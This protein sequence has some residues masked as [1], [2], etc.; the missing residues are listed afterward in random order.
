MAGLQ[1]WLHCEHA[2]SSAVPTPF[3]HSLSTKALAGHACRARVT[4]PVLLAPYVQLA[5]CLVSENVRPL[6]AF[7]MY[8]PLAHGAHD[9][10]SAV[11]LVG[12]LTRRQRLD[13]N[14]PSSQLAVQGAHASLGR[15]S[16]CVLPEQTTSARM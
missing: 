4:E 7:E 9:T 11:S 6:H 10:H 1:F 13:T 12:L 15:V 2:V 14:A 8:W 3:L 16:W 5:H